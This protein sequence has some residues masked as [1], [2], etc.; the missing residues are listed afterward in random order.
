MKHCTYCGKEYPDDL[1]SCP[2]DG[3]PLEGEGMAQPT[4]KRRTDAISPE[5]QHFWDRMTFRQFAIIIVRLQALWL[6][7][8]ALI[9]VTYV[10]RYL[11]RAGSIS[12]LSDLSPAARLELGMLILRALLYI[13]AGVAVIQN[14]EKIL[15][16]LVKD[17][18]S[19]EP[20]R[21]ND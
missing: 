13:A 3:K 6:L 11:T 17:C 10:P 19:K 1:E 18:V 2:V 4:A 16:W 15:S 5:E 8:Y 14:C 7:F 20:P 12:S 9:D 21:H